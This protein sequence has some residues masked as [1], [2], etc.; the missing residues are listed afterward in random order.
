MDS[1][2]MPTDD[3]DR[4]DRNLRALFERDQVH[5]AEQPFVNEIARRVAA[6]RQRR[7]LATRVTQAVLVGGLIAASPWLVSGSALLSVKLDALFSSTAAALDSPLGYGA[8]LVVII[9]AFGLR[10][11][12]FG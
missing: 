2:H 10:R 1:G 12:L 8:G 4:G 5:V 3:D 11:R 7:T 9:A 6:A